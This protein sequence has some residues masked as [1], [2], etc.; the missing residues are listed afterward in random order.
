MRRTLSLS[1]SILAL[2]CCSAVQAQTASTT[3]D[4]SSASSGGVE[5]VV[6][7][8]ERR[9]TNL[10][11]TPIAATVL[12]GTDI[13]N[14]GVT[15]VDQ[16]QFIA[17]SVTIDNFGQGIDFDIRGIGK[18][19]HNSQT[20]PGVIT[21]RDSVATF[22]G[23]FTEEPYYDIASVEVL[24]GSQGTFAGQNA[25]GGAV[26]VTSNNPVIGGG[27][28]GYLQAQVGNYTDVG[29]QGAT[30][31]PI[32]D[33]LAARVAFYGEARDSFYDITSPSGGKYMGNPGRARWGAGRVSLLWKPNEALS[34]LFKTDVDFLDSGAYPADPYTDRLKFVPG[35]TTPNPFYTDLFHIRA[36]AEQ[37]AQDKFVRSSLK[38]DY[39]FAD[40]IT[41]QS[42][43]AY[44]YGITGY[45]ADLY[46]VP[47]TS[48]PYTGIITN[49]TWSFIDSV[50]ETI[51]SQELN[52]I[53]P[54]TGRVTWIL[55]A[56]AQSDMYDF[57]PPASRNF[58]IGQP[59][60]NIFTEYMLQ[61]TNPET[62]LSAFGQVSVALPAGFQLQVGGRY[63][64]TS[65]KNDVFILQYGLPLTDNQ[66]ATSDNFSYKAALNWNVNDDNFLY[67]FLATGF[68][69]GGLNVPVG[70]GIPFP[71]FRPETVTDYEAGWKS[72]LFDGHVHTQ[73][74]GFYDN[75]KNFQ[76]I[77]GYPAFP[78]FGFELNDPNATK[79]YG[80]EAEAQAAFGAFSFDLGV[81]LL[82]SSLGTFYATDPRA[83]TFTPCDPLKG[84]ASVSCIN[85]S[86]HQQ[87]YAPNFTFNI[88][89]QYIFSLGDGDTL[90]PRINYGHV[91]PQWAT[92]FEDPTKGDRLQE[93]N[94]LNGQLAWTHGDYLVTLYG[95]NLTDQHYVGAL[96]SNLDFAGP[97]RQFGIRVMKGF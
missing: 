64:A 80:A 77:V 89:A 74:D 90:T 15:V 65:T 20:T 61:G 18:G 58:L 76:V 82:H 79:L 86:G 95:T 7:T 83:A 41:L 10:Q 97:P 49:D 19:E 96:N 84:P 23:Y 66:K 70:V 30:N 33:T 72:T 28:D 5:T 68:K 31:L 1:T 13:G 42:V 63:S 94:I 29:L 57:P 71:A 73:I 24:R 59:A 48:G 67:A 85:L 25:I 46:G 17:P 2:V 38:V 11:K 43:S 45:K 9:T 62:D 87:T 55:G 14:K 75:F 3:K 27:H 40:G 35:T 81:G 91:S 50:D 36:N 53:S 37:F 4:S 69:P 8:A 92:L 21:Y 54:D 32:S 93:R 22:P 88:G 12:S 56:F 47:D 34:V 60:G 52:L 6:V 78:V 16:L 51:F 44:Q 26:F 39:S